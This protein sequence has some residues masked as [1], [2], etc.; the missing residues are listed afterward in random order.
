MPNNTTRWQE[1]WDKSNENFGF[2]PSYKSKNLQLFLFTF[3]ISVV[4][5]LDTLCSNLGRNSDLRHDSMKV[6]QLLKTFRGKEKKSSNVCSLRAAW[7]KSG[8][9]LFNGSFQ[10]SLIDCSTRPVHIFTPFLRI[11]NN[12]TV[13]Q[14]YVI[15]IE[16]VCRPLCRHHK[17]VR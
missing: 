10:F 4:Q 16:W 14:R 11:G 15:D 8:I 2:T 1:I 5:I 13:S 6:L 12:L 9:K 7:E 17:G 3:Y